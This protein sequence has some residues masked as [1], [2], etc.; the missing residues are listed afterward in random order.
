M[1]VSLSKAC[2]K[3]VLYSTCYIIILRPQPSPPH[4][5]TFLSSM[6]HV[7]SDDKLK[8]TLVSSLLADNMLILSF[9]NVQYGQRDSIKSSSSDE[10]YERLSFGEATSPPAAAIT[11]LSEDSNTLQDTVGA[12]GGLGRGSGGKGKLTSGW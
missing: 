4:L 7:T 9:C 1:R 6:V 5:H 12:R 2:R 3:G 11:T 10:L 8:E